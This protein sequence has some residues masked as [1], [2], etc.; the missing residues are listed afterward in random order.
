MPSESR[1]KDTTGHVRT[2]SP[3]LSAGPDANAKFLSFAFL[4]WPT[5][6]LHFRSWRDKSRQRSTDAASFGEAWISPGGISTPRTT[7]RPEVTQITA[8]GKNFKR[9]ADSVTE[10]SCHAR[11]PASWNLTPPARK[12]EGQT[13]CSGPRRPLNRRTRCDPPGEARS[14]DLPGRGRIWQQRHGQNCLETTWRNV[15]ARPRSRKFPGSHRQP[16]LGGWDE[17][18]EEP[19]ATKLCANASRLSLSSGGAT[20][21]QPHLERAKPKPK[22]KPKSNTRRNSALNAFRSHGGSASA[23]RGREEPKPPPAT[24]RRIC[25]SLRSP[26]AS[27]STNETS[28]YAER[29]PLLAVAVQWAPGKL[30]AALPRQTSARSSCQWHPSSR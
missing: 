12:L 10:G 2:S 8:T 14:L 28:A 25:S 29:E 18:I 5:R 19:D 22:P 20:S 6:H 21:S 4:Q 15:G 7:R 16:R 17:S 3:R 26:R 23:Q 24:H 1:R 30:L 9:G 11:C 27:G 13:S